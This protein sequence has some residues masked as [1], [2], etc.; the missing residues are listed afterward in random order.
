[1]NRL[2]ANN[3]TNSEKDFFLLLTGTACHLV[4][5]TVA[6]APQKQL[7]NVP[8]LCDLLQEQVENGCSET[9]NLSLGILLCSLKKRVRVTG[10]RFLALFSEVTNRPQLANRIQ[11]WSGPLLTQVPSLTDSRFSQSAWRSAESALPQQGNDGLLSASTQN[12]FKKQ[13]WSKRGLSEH[14]V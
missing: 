3:D 13:T 12:G 7:W 8:A 11:K 1:M 6:P 9:W 5:N 14:E 2:K 10:L 4:Q